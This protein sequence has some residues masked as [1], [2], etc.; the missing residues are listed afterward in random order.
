M[1]RVHSERWSNVISLSPR[2]CN[3]NTLAHLGLLDL[4][5]SRARTYPEEIRYTDKHGRSVLHQAM[6]K[7]PSLE[8]I[9]DLLDLHPEAICQQDSFDRSPVDIALCY[10]VNSDVVE[11]MESKKRLLSQLLH[12]KDVVNAIA[13]KYSHVTRFS[14]DIALNRESQTERTVTLPGRVTANI[15]ERRIFEF[16]DNDQ[17]QPKSILINQSLRRSSIKGHKLKPAMGRSKYVTPQHRLSI[18]P[19]WLSFR[20][21]KQVVPLR[22]HNIILKNMRVK[23]NDLYSD[24]HDVPIIED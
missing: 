13:E 2:E 12:N 1:I 23:T 10:G 5:I 19:R 22:R 21:K 20:R 9:Q 8:N 11:Y 6:R 7:N 14:A 18:N 3:V 24:I 17:E 4:A 15:D 16:T